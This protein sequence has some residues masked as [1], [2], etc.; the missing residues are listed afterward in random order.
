[1]TGGKGECL[2]ALVV[3]QVS[4]AQHITNKLLYDAANEA[5]IGVYK[6]ANR[7][8]VRTARVEH[9]QYSHPSMCTE[10][11][12][13]VTHDAL[14]WWKVYVRIFGFVAIMHAQTAC[15]YPTPTF[16]GCCCC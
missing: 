11:P 9:V 6:A 13:Y 15:Q 1:M 12:Q 5:I 4:E 2:C 14:L 7:I 16:N 8:R 10:C 3:P